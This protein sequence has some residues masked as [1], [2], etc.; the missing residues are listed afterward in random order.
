MGNPDC[1]TCLLKYL[2]VGQ[3]ATV[4][5]LYG[6]TDWFKIEKRV[7]QDCMPDAYSHHNYL[8]QLNLLCVQKA[9]TEGTYLNTIKT[10]YDKPI[11]NII[12]NGKKL[13]VFPLKSGKRQGCPLSPL[14]CNIVLEYLATA[15]RGKKSKRN[16]DWKWRRKTHCLHMTGCFTLKT[17]KKPPENY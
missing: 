3:V 11:A 1:L 12:L 5:I 8:T 4:T 14:L 15:I 13:K 16:S 2:Y 7:W 6:I 10:I 17:L 9:G